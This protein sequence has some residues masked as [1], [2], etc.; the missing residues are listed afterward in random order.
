[1]LLCTSRYVEERFV[2]PFLSGRFPCVPLSG[3]KLWEKQVLQGIETLFARQG[4][5][6]V[7]ENQLLLFEMWLN[8]YKNVFAGQEEEPGGIVRSAGLPCLR[9]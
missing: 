6:E 1:M 7:L 9:L 2:V 4:G 3:E 5:E 8:L